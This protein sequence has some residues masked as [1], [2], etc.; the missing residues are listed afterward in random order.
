MN[1]TESNIEWFKPWFEDEAYLEHYSHRNEIEAREALNSIYPLL[2]NHKINHVLDCA[3]GTGRHS[4]ILSESFPLVVGID[5][6]NMLINQAQN[7]LKSQ[8]S[9]KN[10]SSLHFIRADSRNLPFRNKSFDLITSLFTS[11]GYFENDYDNI[12]LLARWNELLGASGFLI[13]DIINPVTIKRRLIPESIKYSK[14]FTFEEKRKVSLGETRIIK[15]IKVIPSSPQIESRVYNESVRLFTLQQIK[16][17]MDDIG[18]QVQ[19]VLGDYR[20]SS[21]IQEESDRMI[22]IAQKRV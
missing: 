19:H 20:G 15:T 14:N 4:L 3:C 16:N 21:Y 12:S 11:F 2:G 22:I 8:Y 9:S 18:L 13:L 7:A 1:F 10:K 17:A 6:S 5:L